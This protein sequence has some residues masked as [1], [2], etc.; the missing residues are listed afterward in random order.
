M[1]R[2]KIATSLMALVVLAAIPAFGDD[3]Q[4]KGMII[5]RTGDTLVVK[6]GAET[7]TVVLTDDT[8]TKDDRGFWAWRNSNCPIRCLYP[9]LRCQLMERLM[10][11]AGL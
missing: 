4:V 5:S 1:H 2:K 9:D 8:T 7:T 3:A 10:T 11:R 6:S